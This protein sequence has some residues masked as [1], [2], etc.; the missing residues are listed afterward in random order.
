MILNNFEV[1]NNGQAIRS[2]K[3]IENSMNQVQ[4]NDGSE[5]KIATKIL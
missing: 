2:E 4:I 3:L 1:F 5:Y